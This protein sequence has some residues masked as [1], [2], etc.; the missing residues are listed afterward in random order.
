MNT[1][2]ALLLALSLAASALAHAETRPV[3]PPDPVD[4]PLLLTAGFL[5]GHPDMDYR[6]KGM[7]AY[8]AGKLDDAR[9]YFSRAAYYAD[10]PSQGMLGE[11]HWN[12][13]GVPRDAVLAY[14]WMDLAAERGY[15]G[16]LRLRE[17]YWSRLDEAQRA[18][19][20]AEGP[21]LYA[22]YGDAAARPR[23][24][25]KLRTARK[26]FVGSRTGYDGG[27]VVIQVP[28]PAGSQTI[29][30][31]KLYD[32]R[33]WDADKYFAW[34]DKVWMKPLVGRVDVGA[35]EKVDAESRIPAAE[36]EVDA[37]E[38]TV[39]DDVPAPDARR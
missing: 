12:G 26:A 21:A 31:S 23:Y 24:D 10:K 20:V 13:D 14:I 3:Q 38:P 37:P 27:N 34:Q 16:F 4:D 22:R 1:R 17:H 15:L 11:M 2:R 36:P 32:E 8:R 33:Y 39:P 35:A 6:I 9:R 7:D 29:D 30:G 18:R 25:F 28:G 19:V 5:S